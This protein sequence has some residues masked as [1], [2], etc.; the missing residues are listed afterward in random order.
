MSRI[1]SQRAPP[2]PMGCCQ[3]RLERLEAVSRCKARRRYTKQLV[4]ARR[5]MAAAH[6]LYLRALRATGA[7]LLHFASAEAEHPRPHSS[8]AHHHQPPP[9]PPPPPTPP[10]P[11]PPPLSPSPTA[12]S[13]TTNSSSISA[14]AIL[15]P[16]PPPPMPSSWDFWDPFAPSSSRSATE[17][18]DWDDA[19]TTV[20][21]AAAPPVVTAAAAVAAPP[22]I[23]TATT[24][25]TTPSELTVVAVPRAGAGKKDLA[26]IATELD[27]YFLKAADAGAS[28]AAL[29][30]APVCEPPETT[31]T[32]ATTTTSLPGKVLSYSKSL[33]PMGWTW[34]GGGG[35]GYGKGNNGFTRF[36]RGDSG[37]SMGSG[38]GGG[39]L[40]HSS[41]V[42]KLYA[43]EK[44]LFLEVKSYEGYKQEHDKKVS[45]FRKQEVKGVDYLKM[46]KNKMEIESLESKML[47]ANQSIE[48]TTS[49]IIRLR[50]SE[51]FPQLLELVAG[52][53]NMWRGMYECHQ[54]QTHIVQ[55]LEYLNNARNTNPTS[56]V[57]RQAALQ[58]E[59][60]VDRWYSAF[61][62]LVKS[63]R[64][65]VY[66]LTGWL[67]LSLFCHHD[68]LTKAQN[69]DIYS[70]CEEW[71]L[72]I[73]RIPDK[74]ASEGIKT[75]LTVI[76]AVVIQQAEEQKQKKRS[77]SAFKEFE[78]KAEEL[79]SLESKY[80][81][82]IGAEG[83]REMSRKS[84]VADKRA[85][86]EALRSRADEEK[87]KY[88]K[89]I[90]V[91]RAMTLNNLQTGFPNVFQAM[92]GFASV[93]MEA[94]ES[95][96]NF[97]RSSDRILD[98][99]RLLT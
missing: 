41:T 22:S 27:E 31:T 80:G 3:S 68:P 29:L 59:I 75:L 61:C 73:D 13:W 42:E 9:S 82:Y 60:E 57:H 24:T 26:E 2:P 14:S 30:E 21:D 6:A 83:Y 96:Y 98:V 23:V 16:P 94:F 84:P 54:V 5:D 39:M 66:S 33:K 48:T 56:N 4:Q 32:A 99:K 92:T 78:K 70:L 20:V 65:Y 62:S 85:K 25:S 90:G 74:V 17:D 28:V 12:R 89:S 47:V 40:S 19:A 1:V 7:T 69:S 76:H 10:P 49:E 95:V 67:R 18:A 35:G 71:Q 37:M 58:L 64:D 93:C 97:K 15:P 44:K 36:G 8:A 51:L 55:Q 79:R 81:P 86:V 77:E 88:E 38:G 34:G 63:Q 43:W 50:E 52:L 53:M 91:T 87:S 72:A 46:E 45:L 11:P